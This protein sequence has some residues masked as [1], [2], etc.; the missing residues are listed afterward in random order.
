MS[1]RG[2]ALQ[3]IDDLALRGEASLVVLGEDLL[4]VDGDDEDAAAAAD[5]LRLDAELFPDFSRQTGGSREVVS[6]AAVIDPYV[7]I[8]FT[9]M[10]VTLSSPP[11][12]LARSISF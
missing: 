5:E 10:A 3:R 9:R 12:S 6:N 11:R 7:H 4:G 8:V 1:G 2:T